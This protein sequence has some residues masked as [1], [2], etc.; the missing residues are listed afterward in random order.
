MADEIDV[1]RVAFALAQATLSML[2]ISKVLDGQ[3]VYAT[4]DDLQTN[5]AL[6]MSEHEVMTLASAMRSSVTQ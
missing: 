2:V 5:G 3:I 6:G 1:G 4:A